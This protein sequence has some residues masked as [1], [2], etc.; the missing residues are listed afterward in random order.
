M[1][2]DDDITDFIVGAGGPVFAADVV[3]HF[4]ERGRCWLEGEKARR[5]AGRVGFV[6]VGE[7]VSDDLLVPL[8]LGAAA[9]AWR[10]TL[11]TTRGR[12]L[13]AAALRLRS[14]DC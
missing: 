2:A 6:S 3:E 8:D 11:L 4:G 10:E 12:A 13:I 5:T 1:R 9:G 14:H 7:C